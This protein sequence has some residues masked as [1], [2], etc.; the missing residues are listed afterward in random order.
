MVYMDNWDNP[1]MLSFFKEKLNFKVTLNK[2]V[3]NNFG[4]KYVQLQ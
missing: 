1:N 4:Q 3:T 2:T